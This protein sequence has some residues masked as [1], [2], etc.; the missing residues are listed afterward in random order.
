MV[1]L[2]IAILLVFLTLIQ[3]INA[4]SVEIDARTKEC[5]I[6][7]VTKGTHCSGSFEILSED[8]SPIEVKVKGPPPTSE[9]FFNAKFFGMF[10]FSRILFFSILFLFCQDLN[11]DLCRGGRVRPKRN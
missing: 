3:N 8:S 6:L 5:F 10:D 7:S 2:S 1:Y 9:I 11:S 4:Y